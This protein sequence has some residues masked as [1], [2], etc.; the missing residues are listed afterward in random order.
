MEVLVSELSGWGN[1]AGSKGWG[2]NRMIQDCAD[3]V[4]TASS[5]GN[6]GVR[7]EAPDADHLGETWKDMELPDLSFLAWL[8]AP[9]TPTD[10]TALIELPPSRVQQLRAH[11]LIFGKSVRW[12]DHRFG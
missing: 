6:G 4:G 3:A 1:V 8:G 2:D 10:A 12:H 11:P 5:S 9:T 7:V